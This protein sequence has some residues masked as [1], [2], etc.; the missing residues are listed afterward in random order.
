MP[1]LLAASVK[2]GWLKFT[3]SAPRAL[4]YGVTI[5]SD[6]AQPKIIGP[7]RI[8]AGRA[9]TVLVFDLKAGTNNVRYRCSGC[10]S[11]TFNY[12]L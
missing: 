8:R 7:G 6:P 11:S 12:S 10:R 3:F 9:A 4:R 2:D 5:W 1:L